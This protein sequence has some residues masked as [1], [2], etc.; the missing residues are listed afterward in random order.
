M[1]KEVPEEQD[2]F[3]TAHHPTEIDLFLFFFCGYFDS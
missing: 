1:T 3:A 2:V